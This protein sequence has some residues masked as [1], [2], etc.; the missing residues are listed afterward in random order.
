MKVKASLGWYFRA[1]IR[2]GVLRREMF[3]LVLVFAGLHQYNKFCV[4]L[5]FANGAVRDS[6][7]FELGSRRLIL[8][9][10]HVQYAP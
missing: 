4:T 9:S 7:S 6:G 8:T 10:H 3:V 2:K 5:F 1:G